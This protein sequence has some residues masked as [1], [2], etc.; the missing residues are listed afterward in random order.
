MFSGIHVVT[1]HRGGQLECGSISSVPIKIIN[2]NNQ[3]LHSLHQDVLCKS[4]TLLDS[5][6]LLSMCS[7]YSLR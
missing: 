1:Q 4:V 7:G 6:T 3:L 5:V 2:S